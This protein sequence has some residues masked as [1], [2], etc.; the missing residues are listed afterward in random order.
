M[1][2]SAAVSVLAPILIR[3]GANILAEIVGKKSPA[4]G[5]VV[6][7]VAA[8]LNVEP[9]PEAIAEAHERNPVVVQE[10]IRQVEVANEEKWRAMADIAESINATM[11]N[12][13]VSSGLLYRVWRPVFG[14]TLSLCFFVM[15]LTICKGV[16][17]GET[18]GLNSLAGLSG[19][20][21]ALFAGAFGVMGVYVH[22]R[23]Q[24]KKN[25]V[26]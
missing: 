8:A 7:E 25:G 19:F 6:K 23:T 24:E 16:W 3:S 18:A 14:L 11:Q 12:E 4:A 9:T 15:V 1:I 13:I 22:N 20:L 21:L 26:A 2:A 5:Q 10:T 17:M